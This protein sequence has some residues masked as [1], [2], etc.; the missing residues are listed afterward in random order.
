MGSIV[1]LRV[2]AHA[3]PQPTASGCRSWL[4]QDDLHAVFVPDAEL[5]R[6]EGFRAA[7]DDVAVWRSAVVETDFAEQRGQFVET[8]LYVADCVMP[9]CRCCEVGKC[10]GS[11]GMVLKYHAVERRYAFKTR[12]ASA[13]TCTPLGSEATPTAARAKGSA[14][15][16]AM[17]SLK[18]AKL[19]KS[20][21]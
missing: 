10:C 2:W 14:I 9:P 17:T 8:A 19:P 15:N 1:S 7:V 18:T 12:T 20:V 11:D 16:S 21:R 3:T 4:R 13:S 6:F 5:Q